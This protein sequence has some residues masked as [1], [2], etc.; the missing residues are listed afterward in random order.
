MCSQ[1][2]LRQFYYRLRVAA[3][4]AVSSS[5]LPGVLLSVSDRRGEIYMFLRLF[6]LYFVLG[7]GARVLF[8]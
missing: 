8:F 7:G 2:M 5:G 3:A 1:A 6:S 4:A